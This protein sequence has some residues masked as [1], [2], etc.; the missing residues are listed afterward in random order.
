MCVRFDWAFGGAEAFRL[1]F[2]EGALERNPLTEGGVGLYTTETLSNGF[3]QASYALV[4]R[5]LGPQ[6]VLG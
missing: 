1:R 4:L 6:W 2:E 5:T 3:S